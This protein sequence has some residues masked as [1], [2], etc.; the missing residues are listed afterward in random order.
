MDLA[1]LLALAE[2]FYTNKK[3]K[4]ACRVASYA[5]AGCQGNLEVMEF[6][7]MVVGIAHDLL[8]DTDIPVDALREV[9]TKEQFEAVWILTKDDDQDYEDYIESIINSNNKLAFIVKKADMKDHLTLTATLTDKL[10]EKYF[11]VLKYFL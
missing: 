7:A 11:P 9:L 5:V 2:K 4:H 8:E 3:Y 6:D 1:K 10:K